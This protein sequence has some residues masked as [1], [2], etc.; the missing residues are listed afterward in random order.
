MSE[1]CKSEITLDGARYVLKDEKEHNP[2]IMTFGGDNPWPNAY[3]EK[4]MTIR[5]RNGRR[6]RR[7]L[8]LKQNGS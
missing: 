2:S 6:L 3:A 7:R 8:R 5:L 1:T 4:F